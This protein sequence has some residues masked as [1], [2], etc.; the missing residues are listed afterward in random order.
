LLRLIGAHAAQRHFLETTDIAGVVA[1]DL[2]LFLTTGDRDLAGIGH[3][4]VIA[5]VGAGRE[6]GLVLTHQDASNA[7]CQAAEDLVLGADNVP[8][9]IDVVLLGEGSFG[10]HCSI[11]LMTRRPDSRSPKGATH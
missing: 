8:L 2:L 9:G 3:D 10:G 6:G 5:V 1:V 7:Y 11:L 4:N